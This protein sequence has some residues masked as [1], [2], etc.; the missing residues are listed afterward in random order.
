MTVSC[1][2]VRSWLAAWIDGERTPLS[3]EDFERHLA[4]CAD[5][6]RA[7]REQRGFLRTVSTAYVPAPVPPSLQASI[8]RKAAWRRAFSQRVAPLVT[9]AAV[10]AAIALVVFTA[11][12]PA[13]V[14]AASLAEAS[15]WAHEGLASGALPLDV[16]AAQRGGA[17][18]VAHG[19]RGLHRGAPEA[20]G[21]HARLQR[22]PGGP[23][24]GGLRRGREL[25]AQ[26]RARQPGHCP[27]ARRGQPGEC[28]SDGAVPE[29]EVHHQHP[30]RP[31][32]HQLER[33]LAEL[34]AGVERPRHGPRLLCRVSR[35]ELGPEER[36]GLPR[37]ALSPL[38]QAQSGRCSKRSRKAPDIRPMGPRRQRPR[39]PPRRIP[40][41]TACSRA[42][43]WAGPRRSGS[44]RPRSGPRRTHPCSRWRPSCPSRVACRLSALPKAT[45][46][47]VRL[48]PTG[49]AGSRGCG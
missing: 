44:H 46:S 35:G 4:E 39:L 21:L 14:Q 11:L 10:A 47:Q 23:A 18:P 8:R 17:V 2:S 34:R 31:P 19:A 16:E 27:S 12:R 24:G 38:S 6:A 25:R 41:V 30:A 33:G 36:R 49:S 15:A 37:D 26:R 40:T 28:A 1:E 7:A 13:P 5:C 43:R 20:G 42:A 22:R 48:A 32:R 3:P 29:H 9:A 45:V